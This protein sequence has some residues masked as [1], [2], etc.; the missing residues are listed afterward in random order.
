[1][2]DGSPKVARLFPDYEAVER[3]YYRRTGIFPPMHIIAIRRELAHRPARRPAKSRER[4]SS[5]VDL[6]DMITPL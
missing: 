6:V 4:N 1:M 5:G 3:D 2:L